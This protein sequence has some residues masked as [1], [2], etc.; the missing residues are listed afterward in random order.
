MS[1]VFI[2]HVEEDG[3]V[4]LEIALALECHQPRSTM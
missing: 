2:S 1:H 3:N 4:A